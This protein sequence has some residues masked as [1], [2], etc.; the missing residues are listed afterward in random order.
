MASTGIAPVPSLEGLPPGALLIRTVVTSICGSDLSGQPCAECAA[1]A[2]RGFTPEMPKGGYV[3]NEPGGETFSTGPAGVGGS[4]HELMGE[5]AAYVGPCDDVE[6]GDRVLCMSAGWALTLA[7]KEFESRTGVSARCLLPVLSGGFCEYF[8]STVDVIV[9]VPSVYPTPDFDPLLYVAAQPFGTII[10][11]AAKLDSVL[12]KKIVIM[13]R[14]AP[15]TLSCPLP[16]SRPV[17][18]AL[19]RHC[20]VLCGTDRERGRTAS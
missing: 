11:A 7:R 3:G 2:W 17:G 16:I 8:V 4:G 15:Q 9:P 6:I 14:A 19:T 10:K 12:T 20:A 1:S 18:L 5:V 13:V